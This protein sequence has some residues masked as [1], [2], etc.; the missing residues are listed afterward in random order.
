MLLKKKHAQNRK[1]Y[2]SKCTSIPHVVNKQKV[3]FF[4]YIL[5]FLFIFFFLQPYK[6]NIFYYR[7]VAKY[8]TTIR[9]ARDAARVYKPL[10]TKQQIP[11]KK[12]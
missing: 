8:N 10:K 6:N 5:Q 4:L 11:V 12:Q 9:I 7:F 2:N 1:I 3:Y